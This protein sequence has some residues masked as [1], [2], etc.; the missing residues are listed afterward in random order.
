VR[1]KPSEWPSEWDVRPATFDDVDRA[2]DMFNARSQAFYGENQST[3][4]EMIGWWKS[5]RFDLAEGSQIV[6]DEE[7]R[8]IGWA[9]VADPGE[10]YVS[11]GCGVIAHPDV[12]GDDALWDGLYA[13]ALDRARTFVP[14]APAETQVVASVSTL[15]R[16]EARRSAAERTGFEMVRVQN[17]MRIDL[18]GEPPAPVWPDGIAMRTADVQR[19]LEAI[20]RADMEAFRDHWGHV[21]RTFEFELEG[22]QDYVRGKGDNLDPT[23]WFLAVDGDEIAG[24]SICAPSIADDETRG[25]VDGLCVRP[26]WRRRG[27][28]LALLHQSFGEFHHRGYGAV[29][30]DMDSENLTG[31]LGLYTK[32]GM[33]VIRRL[34][35]Y[36]KVLR[37]GVDLVKRD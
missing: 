19:D 21:E 1:V 16:D 36:E 32:A 33:H 14:L 4:D 35:T 31:A 3:A 34:I 37:D 7:G 13:W 10:P 30:L 15:E 11:V 27:I 12:E 17:K 24:C 26:A 2:V 25:Y 5:P 18:D 23:L 28:A 29:E 22:W 9:H 8:M 6:L 20:V